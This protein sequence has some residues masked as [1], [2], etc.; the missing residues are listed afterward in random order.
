MSGTHIWG[1]SPIDGSVGY[2]AADAFT[3]FLAPTHIVA[4]RSAAIR[5]L[6]SLDSSPVAT[7][8]MGSCVAS[9]AA[10]DSIFE[11]EGGY[12]DADALLP[13]SDLSLDIATVAER[14]IGAPLRA[15]GRSGAGLDPAG[16]VFLSLHLAGVSAPRFLDLQSVQL[17]ASLVEAAQMTRG[18]V[19]FFEDHAAIA[20]DE[21]HAIHVSADGV[22]QAEVSELTT[23]YGPILRRRQP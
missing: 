18:Q 15:G 4:V 8:P 19:L 12:L 17:G 16:L 14:L 20:V 21:A 7:L 23:I 13:L 11:V 5:A 10:S 9:T 22:V 3:A 6:P 1:V 2:V